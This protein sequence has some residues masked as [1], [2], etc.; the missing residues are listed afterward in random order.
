MIQPP[1]GVEL[2]RVGEQIAQRLGEAIAIGFD[3]QRQ[4]HIDLKPVAPGL[5]VR[6]RHLGRAR[7]DVGSLAASKAQRDPAALEPRHIQEVIHQPREMPHLA[8]DDEPLVRRSL[9]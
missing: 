6:A 4:R 5:D 7:H 9:R 3:R 2:R 8:L 1:G